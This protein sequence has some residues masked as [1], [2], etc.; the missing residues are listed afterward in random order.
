MGV[1]YREP[2][3]PEKCEL[4]RVE[5]TGWRLGITLATKKDGILARRIPPDC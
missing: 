4:G 1:D 2:D 5:T 3:M